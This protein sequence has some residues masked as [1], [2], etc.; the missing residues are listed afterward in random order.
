[1]FAWGAMS[2]SDVENIE[3]WF[4]YDYELNRMQKCKCNLLIAY[5]KRIC[6]REKKNF[7]NFHKYSQVKEYDSGKNEK[8]LSSYRG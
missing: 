3:R 4:T 7:K 8:P 1:M 2:N 6:L 5:T